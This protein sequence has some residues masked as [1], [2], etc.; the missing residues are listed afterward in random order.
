V[1]TRTRYYCLVVTAVTFLFFGTASLSEAAEISFTVDPTS[2]L[3]LSAVFSG[4]S[5]GEQGNGSLVTTYSGTVTVDVDNLGAPTSIDFLSSALIAANSGD[6]L[7]DVGGGPSGGNTGPAAP[8]NY[9]GFAATGFILAGDAYAAIRNFELDATTLGG[10]L[11]VTGGTTFPSTQ[12]FTVSSGTADF[13][14]EGGL[15]AGPD[16]STSDLAGSSAVN[17]ASTASTYVRVGSI[18]TLTLPVDIDI[19]I[20]DGAGI[21]NVSGILTATADISTGDF[22]QDGDQDGN[23]FLLWQR[24][25]GTLA[26]ANLNDGDGTFDGAVLGDDLALWA[27]GVGASLGLGVSISVVP[28]PSSL[29]LLGL[30]LGM[31]PLRTRRRVYSVS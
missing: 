26:G 16:A 28:E 5:L 15:F 2:S 14:I 31:V 25:F 8:A 12:T 4:I 30:A 24:G 13:N 9:G 10:S 7:P 21:A 17:Q 1:K 6:W 19:D 23:D 27:S 11:A 29:A 18:V 20:D 22:D 3:S